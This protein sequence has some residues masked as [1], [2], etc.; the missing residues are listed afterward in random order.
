LTPA[1]QH[2]L[3]LS[4]PILGVYVLVSLRHAHDSPAVFIAVV[5]A[6]VADYVDGAV[7]RRTRSE[8]V[9]GRM[10]DNWCDAGFLALVFAGFAQAR[11]WS[12][13]G[14]VGANAGLDWWPLVALIASFGSYALRWL[15]ASMRGTV[16]RRSP[17][18]HHA[19]IANYVLA[20]VGGAAAFPS[21]D[22]PSY[23]V[24]A[25]FFA[26][27]A[28]NVIAAADNVKRLASDRE[29]GEQRAGEPRAPGS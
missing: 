24:S 1:P 11:V 25:P 27:V 20:L 9:A 26:V 12:T 21:V 7:A 29:G 3:S 23:V 8:T 2:L 15:A 5:L 14:R 6:C 22:L 13:A 28:L 17:R 10:L 4:R 19:G 18:G 16:P